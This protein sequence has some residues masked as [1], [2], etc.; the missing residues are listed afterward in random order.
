[1]VLV[2]GDRSLHRVA[3]QIDQP[4]LRNGIRDAADR[5]GLVRGG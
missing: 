3:D 5:L 2:L 1:M 4:G